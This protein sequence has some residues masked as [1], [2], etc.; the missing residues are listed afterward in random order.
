[1]TSFEN[2]VHKKRAGTRLCHSLLYEIDQI[3]FAQDEADMEYII[4][5]LKEECESLGFCIDI[6]KT[7]YMSIHSQVSI[8]DEKVRTYSIF[9]NILYLL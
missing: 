3:I 4:Q 5:K 7:E 1:M 9:I 2:L 6:K 8:D